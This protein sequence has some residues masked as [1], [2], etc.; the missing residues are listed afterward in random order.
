MKKLHV[1]GRSFL[2]MRKKSIAK[3]SEMERKRRAARPAC[4]LRL[5][6]CAFTASAP[7]SAAKGFNRWFCDPKNTLDRW[8]INRTRLTR[9]SCAT[10]YHRTA[11]SLSLS[12]R[13]SLSLS[14]TIVTRSIVRFLNIRPAMFTRSNQY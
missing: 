2:T 10:I 5:F 4:S 14:H 8:S 6:A 9:R 13:P 12:S 1:A 3:K 11:L 7:K